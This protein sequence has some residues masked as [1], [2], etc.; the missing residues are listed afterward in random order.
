MYQTL[1]GSM[2]AAKRIVICL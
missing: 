1:I 2:F